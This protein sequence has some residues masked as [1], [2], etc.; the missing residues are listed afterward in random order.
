MPT[1]PK[2]TLSARVRCRAS[3]RPLI[4]AAAQSPND[5]EAGAVANLGRGSTYYDALWWRMR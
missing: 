1:L 4:T 3:K 2:P 5:Y